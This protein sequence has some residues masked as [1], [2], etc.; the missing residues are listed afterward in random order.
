MGTY[1]SLRDSLTPRQRESVVTVT[2]T[3]VFHDPSL[4]DLLHQTVPYLTVAFSRAK[5]AELVRKTHEP[6]F[7]ELE[8]FS[9]EP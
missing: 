5:Q 7:K 1:K 2:S 4:A 6:K 3:D 8:L 9:E